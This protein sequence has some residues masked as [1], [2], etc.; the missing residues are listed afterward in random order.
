MKRHTTLSKDGPHISHLMFADDLLIA[1]DSDIHHIE[2]ILEN[3]VIGW[4]RR[5]VNL[6]SLVVFQVGAVLFGFR[7]G[8]PTPRTILLLGVREDV[9]G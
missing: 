4:G 2:M 6:G 9:H 1:S 3:F 8:G 5:E 7:L